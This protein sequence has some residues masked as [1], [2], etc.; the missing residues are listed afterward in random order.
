MGGGAVV[1]ERAAVAAGSSSIGVTGR[2][3]FGVGGASERESEAMG[4]GMCHVVFTATSTDAG[5]TGGPPGCPR[6]LQIR[7]TR[8]MAGEGV[9][10]PWVVAPRRS[11]EARTRI[12]PSGGE[13][14]PLRITLS[15]RPI[16]F[17]GVPRPLPGTG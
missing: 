7:G 6:T 16:T 1:V 15:V 3:G 8:S 12:R 11:R 4:F 10:W 9:P 17:A 13:A 14:R 2:E 5:A